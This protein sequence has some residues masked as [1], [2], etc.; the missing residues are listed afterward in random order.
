MT[1]NNTQQSSFYDFNSASF[2]TA[3][4]FIGVWYVF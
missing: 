3:E 1:S 2:G 4:L